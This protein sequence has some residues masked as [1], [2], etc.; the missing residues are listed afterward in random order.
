MLHIQIPNTLLSTEDNNIDIGISNM[1][2][3]VYNFSCISLLQYIILYGNF[4]NI[5]L[6]FDLIKN[7]LF[8]S[9]IQY[10][11]SN[12]NNNNMN[13]ISKCVTDKNN[14]NIL[15]LAINNGNIASIRLLIKEIVDFSNLNINNINSIIDINE[16]LNLNSN[17][18]IKP[19]N[20]IKRKHHRK[21]MNR[22][23][24]IKNK[25]LDR[26]LILL[27]SQKN[28]AGFTPMELAL[29]INRVSSYMSNSLYILYIYIY[30]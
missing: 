6:I 5:K 28:D 18:V 16:V 30:I 24:P 20:A 29:K 12:N 13:N 21:Y 7:I 3:I 4:Q 25:K 23:I 15:H 17:T 2:H 11:L 10:C 1:N 19:I 27:L 14:N 8:H 22:P 26:Y 9:E